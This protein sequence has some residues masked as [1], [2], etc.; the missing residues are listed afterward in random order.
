MLQFIRSK[1][2]SIFVKILFVL[3]IASF[4]IWGIGDTMFGSPAGRVA[5][6]VGDDVRYTTQEVA[7]AFEAA[8][9]RLGMPLTAE[10]AM[11]LG[12][13][14]QVIE[15]LVTEGLM[16]A[17]TRSL[18]LSVG[19]DRIAE[20]VR[21]RFVDELGRFDRARYQTF[22]ATN[23][24]SEDEF[25]SRLQQDFARRQLIDAMV[26]SEPIPAPVVD[27]LLNYREERRVGEVA[28]IPAASVADP[29]EPERSTLESYF[30]SNR[31]RYQEPE[32]RTVSWVHVSPEAIAETVEVAEDDLRSEYDAR[33]HQFS[34]P[35]RRSVQQVLFDTEDEA[36]AA[37]RRI[38]EGE[39][40]AAVAEATT[41]VDAASLDLGMLRSDDLPV[42][43]GDA[44]FALAVNIVSTP[45]ESPFGWH[46][47][48]VRTVEP[49]VTI[50]YDE[51]RE[52]LR[53]ELALDR[54]LDVV[55]TTANRLEDEL[56]G[57]ATLEEAA[58]SMALAVT[59]TEAVDRSGRN[60][61][62]TAVAGLPGGRFF[63]L[64]FDTPQGQLS[65]LGEGDNGGFFVLRV[66][67]VE[68]PRIPTLDDVRE[69]VVADWKA[70]RRMELAEETAESLLRD[71]KGG[72]DL[73]TL[74]AG[75]W[76]YATLPPVTRSGRG[77]PAGYP[78][79]LAA[80]L[81]A[82][83]SA[84]GADLTA[85]DTTA[86]VV[87]LARIEPLDAAEQ[88]DRRAALAQQLAQGVEADV[89]ELL[90]ANLQS[91]FGVD[92]DRQ[93]VVRLYEPVR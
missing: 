14:D 81:F 89:I 45:V 78:D 32:Y 77:M 75:R 66:E 19:T 22:L 72:R 86:V 10:Q 56:A 40:F 12:I 59:R 11:Q 67:G 23:D 31:G 50:G 20:F 93:S 27:R 80:T 13:L 2:T 54:A 49:G 73:V 88:A 55:Y 83:P 25:V 57:G 46:L 47:F 82:I 48:R 39:D 87:R 15:S 68:A 36:A 30:E 33:I 63:E 84:G 5:V 9:R 8:R 58:R 85:D 26:V 79:T 7:N 71:V 60:R 43:T 53:R 64:A 17:A 18:D 65:T 91:R 90:L 76:Q 51:I 42:G 38:V 44:V 34:T 74:A 52:R 92:V 24:W 6:K 61:A 62:G 41:G 3:L 21:S 28:V 4:A 37:Y 29:G 70:E 35:E 1:V 69:R 16:T